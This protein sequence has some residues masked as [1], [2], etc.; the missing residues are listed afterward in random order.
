MI[1]ASRYVSPVLTRYML[2]SISKSPFSVK[3][4]LLLQNKIKGID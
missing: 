3:R 1:A 4:G 2:Q